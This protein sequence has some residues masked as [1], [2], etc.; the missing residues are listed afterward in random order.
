MDTGNAKDVFLFG[1]FRLDRRQGRLFQ[2]TDDS[3]ST[4][5]SLGSR[6]F[7][8]LCVLVER[9]GEIVP[10]QAIMDAVWPDTAVEEANLTVQISALRRVLGNECIEGSVIRTIPG[11]G[12]KFIAPVTREEMASQFNYDHNFFAAPTGPT[13]SK[14]VGRV[15]QIDT[16][17]LLP[18]DKPSI[19]VLPFV[20]LSSDPEQEYFSYGI[21]EDIIT[22][23]SRSRSLLVI[24]R[25]SSFTYQGRAMDVKRVAHELG[26]RY[27]VEGSVRRSGSRVRVTAQLIDAETGNHIWAE[28]YDRALEDI[29]AVQDE[30][31]NAVSYAIVPAISHAERQRAIRKPPEN[32]DAWEAYQRALWHLAKSG[33]AGA[34]R[35]QHFLEHAIQLDPLFAAPHAMLAGVHLNTLN[36]GTPFS[37]WEAVSMAEIEV[38]RALNLD[39]D[40][41]SAL[42]A[43]AW[44]A[45]CRGDHQGALQHAERAISIDPNY[46]GAYL[47]KA[48]ALVYSGRT[49]EAREADVIALRLNPRDPWGATMRLLLT[50]A[51]Y[52]EADYVNALVAA[53]TAIR[54]YPDYPT[55]YRYVAASLGQLG[56]VD[57][58][59]EALREAMTVSPATFDPY[60][61]SRL[62]WFRQVDYE[63]LLDGL[64]KAGWDG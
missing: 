21:G 54:D 33:V 2:C 41:P 45:F 63:H 26:V 14:S 59:R 5:V 20:N 8:V 6:A 10:K 37:L 30:I 36:V 28:H 38:R 7:G 44:V 4:P 64:R 51:H 61:R 15:V 3:T 13:A 39:P 58:A 24:A 55:P 48:A 29:F 62:P 22:A 32:L 40:E 52:F 53:R 49:S 23:L 34:E 9:Q 35:G 17:A 57:E 46:A 47:S 19:A 25:N 27:V 43:L 42:V 56:R 1:R 18:P 60:V 11:R 50:V 12:Y 16:G 31:T